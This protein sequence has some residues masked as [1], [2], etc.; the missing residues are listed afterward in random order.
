MKYP[1]KK[2]TL[3]T[4][5]MSACGATQLA[6]EGYFPHQTI[7]LVESEIKG[8]DSKPNK[9]NRKKRAFLNA[10][11]CHVLLVG[12][13]QYGS[14]GDL[15]GC[16]NDVNDVK[17][18]LLYYGWD[19]KRIKILVDAQASKETVIGE[20]KWLVSH[21]N[22]DDSLYFHFSGHGSWTLTKD[23]SGWES[24]IC[25]ADCGDNWDNGIITRTE[26]NEALERPGGNLQ[27][28]LDC[29]FSGGMFPTYRVWKE[30]PSEVYKLL[31]ESPIKERLKN[32]VRALPGPEWLTLTSACDRLKISQQEMLQCIKKGTLESREVLN[33]PLHVRV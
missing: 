1:L 22:E 4:I 16:I 28:K 13:N 26:I 11:T 3:P 31:Y 30:I 12:V 6:A 18:K 33:G 15:K 29:C 7:E 20:I 32:G 5:Y 19:K 17:G 25:C 10:K 2:I 27:V 21:C 14:H 24:C 9:T 8:T 23:G